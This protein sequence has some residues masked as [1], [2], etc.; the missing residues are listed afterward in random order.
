MSPEAPQYL[1]HI[2]IFHPISLPTSRLAAIESKNLHKSER[3]DQHIVR[4]LIN[5]KKGYF[6][7]NSCFINTHDGHILKNQA[8]KSEVLRLKLDTIE[9][10]ASSK[11]NLAAKG[12]SLGLHRIDNEKHR[13]PK[14]Q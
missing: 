14:M 2:D 8:Q 10:I 13:D 7:E 9:R 12:L 3:Q 1:E 5:M 6:K 11:T 4:A